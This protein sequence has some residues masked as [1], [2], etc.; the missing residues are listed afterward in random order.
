METR[1][2]ATTF[3]SVINWA[4]THPEWLIKISVSIDVRFIDSLLRCLIVH[5]KNR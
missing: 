5:G 3:V 4:W 1:A 2:T